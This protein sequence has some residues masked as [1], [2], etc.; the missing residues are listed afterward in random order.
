MWPGPQ[1]SP[2]LVALTGGIVGPFRAVGGECLWSVSKVESS[3]RAPRLPSFILLVSFSDSLLAVSI[4]DIVYE[5]LK[6]LMEN[7]IFC[8][9]LLMTFSYTQLLY[10]ILKAV[11]ILH[12]KLIF[13]THFCLNT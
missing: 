9:V 13:N 3:A 10:Q 5:V 11:E 6:G 1:F 12:M 7:F 2:D 8:E 4:L